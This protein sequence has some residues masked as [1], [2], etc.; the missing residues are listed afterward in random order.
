MSRPP[1][2]A[3][4][5]GPLVDIKGRA[6]DPPKSSKA[7]FSF[8]IAILLSSAVLAASVLIYMAW[9]STPSDSIASKTT[10]ALCSQDGRRDIY[11]V[12]AHN[13]QVQCLVVH[14]DLFIDVGDLGTFCAELNPIHL[15]PTCFRRHF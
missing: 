2:S 12:D 14:D 13:T 4:P 9:S 1:E 7:S 5:K 3:S 11:T 10:F 6:I 15:M 8:N